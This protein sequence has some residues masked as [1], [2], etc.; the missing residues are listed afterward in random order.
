M[1]SIK[2]LRHH[3]LDI[4]DLTLDTHSIAVIGHNG[5][6]KTTLLE[7]LAGMDRPLAGDVLID[8]IE[9]CK[10]RVG[11]V[12]EFPDRT[13]LFSKVYDEVASSFRFTK[14]DAEETDRE[15]K[16]ALALLGKEGLIDRSTRSLSG[17]EKALVAFA[18][19]I[20]NRPDILIL[21][22]VD[23]HLDE[24]SSEIIDDAV[25][26][27]GLPVVYCT[28]DMDRAAK[29]ETVV[30]MERGRVSSCGTPSEVFTDMEGSCLYPS[31]WR[32]GL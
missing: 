18:A 2:A 10:R 24:I 8:G 14:V 20:A 13:M 23:S 32:L 1:I 4:P 9:P 21:D 25:S 29:A 19:A 27:S 7:V 31:I 5:A 11:W 26:A 30:L 22:E 16:S 3:L 15:V 28:Q 17:G 6:G 12:G